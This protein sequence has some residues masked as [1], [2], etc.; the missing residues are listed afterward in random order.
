MLVYILF[1]L[2]F[3]FLLKG[4]DLLVEGSSAIAKRYGLSPLIIG[5]TIVSFGTSLPE[6]VINVFA[7]FKGSSD[8][9]IGNHEPR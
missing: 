6:L 7:S 1:I 4:A 9:A 2:G 8:I 3:V 5:L